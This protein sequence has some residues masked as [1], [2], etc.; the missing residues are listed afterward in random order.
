MLDILKKQKLNDRIPR[1]LPDDVIVAHKTGELFGAKHDA[2]IVF[3]K[4]GDFMI[5]VLS[6][7]Q[8]VKVAVEKIARFSEDIFNYFEQIN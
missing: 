7:T 5:I 3:L 8:N 6:D 1:Y 4:K 2:G